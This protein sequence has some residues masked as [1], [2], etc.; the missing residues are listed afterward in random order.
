MTHQAGRWGPSGQVANELGSVLTAVVT[1]ADA[2]A[3][4]ELN[5]GWRLQQE[6]GSLETALEGALALVRRLSHLAREAPTAPCGVD[7][8]P[9]L[10]APPLRLS[11][12]PRPTPVFAGTIGE[13]S[14]DA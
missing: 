3:E 10:A 7:L 8:A 5:K 11:G 1:S 12:S 9:G 13:L 4:G 6:L 14:L 2:I